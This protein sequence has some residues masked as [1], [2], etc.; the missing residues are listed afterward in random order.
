MTKTS[1]LLL[2]FIVISTHS[3]GQKLGAYYIPISIDS[4]QGGRLRFL[5]DSTVELSNIP[6]HMSPSLS[7]VYKYVQTDTTIQIFPQPLKNPEI[8]TTSLY[9]NDFVLKAKTILMKID[10][11]FI[12]H[13]RSLIYVKQ[14]DFDK[15]PDIIYLIDGKK[16]IQDTG[17]RDGYGL[18]KKMPKRNRALER[19]LKNVTKDNSTIELVRGLTAYNLF[20]IKY[21]FGT[22]VITTKK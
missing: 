11:G 9:A 8:Q 20:G 3:F 16:F 17:E 15:H 19:K 1:F 22:I 7:A 10:R 5:T 13:E 6:R 4:N 21:V 18:V 14:S 2:L 12:D